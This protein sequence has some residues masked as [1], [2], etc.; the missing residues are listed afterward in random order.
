MIIVIGGVEFK[1]LEVF[2]VSDDGILTAEC[3]KVDRGIDTLKFKSV[4][5]VVRVNGQNLSFDDCAV[6]RAREFIDG[7]A[8][9]KKISF[10][11]KL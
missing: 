11:I 4:N 3:L 9:F 6:I 10:E 8:G 2:S 1:R 7:S 5:V